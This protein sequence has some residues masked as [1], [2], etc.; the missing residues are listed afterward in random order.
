MDYKKAVLKNLERRQG[1]RLVVWSG[2]VLGE[3]IAE[4]LNELGI[5]VDYWIG[6]NEAVNRKDCQVVPSLDKLEG[7]PDINFIFAAAYNGQR[8]MVEELTKYHYQYNKD[9]V[10]T[11]VAIYVDDL[12]MVDPLLTY[13]REEERWAGIVP[14]GEEDDQSYKVLVLGNSTSES[15]LGGMKCW[16]YYLWKKLSIEMKQNV[17]VYNGGLSGFNSA[18]EFLK[19]SR[20]GLELKPDMVVSL[21]GCNDV[22]GFGT[23]VKGK[24]FLNSYQKRMWDNIT[25]TPNAV[26]DSLYMRNMRKLFWGVETEKSDFCLWLENEKRM[27]ALCQGFGIDFIGYLQPL[28]TQGG[29]KMDERMKKLLL[30]AGT[31]LEE[32]A[33]AQKEFVDGV[34]SSLADFPYIRDLTKLFYNMTEMYHD[35]YH[36]VE[37]GNQLIAN[38]V[39]KD[40]IEKGGRK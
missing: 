10:I 32:Y 33:K 35:H 14:F 30:D 13:N 1:R 9:F 39:A 4:T 37:T 19:L 25:Q 11:N 22:E 31:K 36:Y 8:E 6:E 17:V 16:S 38:Q 26:P 5:A 7:G 12:N 27:Y 28:I 20:D 2:G 15:S 18:Q 21:S 40:I 34:R 3:Y 29:Y 24:L 23:T